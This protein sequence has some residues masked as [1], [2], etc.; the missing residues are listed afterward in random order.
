MTNHTVTNIPSRIKRGLLPFFDLLPLINIGI[1]SDIT[2]IIKPITMVLI[3]VRNSTNT[4]TI[5]LN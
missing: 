1:I 4:S 3:S 2:V 5:D